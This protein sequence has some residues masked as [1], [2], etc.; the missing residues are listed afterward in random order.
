MAQTLET[1]Q[2][3]RQHQ[4]LMEIIYSIFTELK[5]KN[6][7]DKAKD[8]TKKNETDTGEIAT[9]LY[10]TVDCIKEIQH[11]EKDIASNMD[12]IRVAMNLLAANQDSLQEKDEK[13]YN[14]I[15]RNTDEFLDVEEE[16]QD[17]IRGLFSDMIGNIKSSIT[18]FA[19]NLFRP[20]PRTVILAKS[21]IKDIS[22]I[23][24][25]YTGKNAV[26][27]KSFKEKAK[28]AAAADVLKSLGT[29]ITKIGTAITI[30]IKGIATALQ[31]FIYVIFPVVLL[32]A[33]GV[34]VIGLYFI[35]KL[36]IDSII[37]FL[38]NALEHIISA[39]KPIVDAISGIYESVGKVLGTI[40]GGI[41]QILGIVNEAWNTLKTIASTIVGFLN[42]KNMIGTAVNGIKSFFGGEQKETGTATNFELMTGPICQAVHDF[43]DMVKG[44]LA[45]IAK[46][47]A[48][49]V[50]R[51][52]VGNQK[53]VNSSN[54]DTVTY[55]N[56]YS[57]STNTSHNTSSNTSTAMDGRPDNNFNKT[58]IAKYE[59]EYSSNMTAQAKSDNSDVVRQ[60][61]E[62]NSLLNKLLEALQSNTAKEYS[63]FGA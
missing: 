37:S 35:V 4:E 23:F 50:I 9:Y 61:K 5:T 25:T 51:T 24:K 42:P 30:S 2:A 31:V 18:G 20:K 55:A 22:G 6:S 63:I 11:S 47:K 8:N 59:N 54:I 32:G 57:N 46:T 12:D 53:T 28:D 39:V 58:N 38:G 62:T 21:S 36:L 40:V 15:V 33:V 52:N 43:A 41:E 27:P 16:K 3:N 13:Y 14:A 60:I 7:F 48:Y 19:N 1:A 10:T 26:E 29:I 56:G 49:E 17:G 34:L 45:T 44:Y